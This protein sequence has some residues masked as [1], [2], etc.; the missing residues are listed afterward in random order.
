M[1][2]LDEPLRRRLYDYVCEQAAPVSRE[3]AS[4]AADIVRT[5]AAYH[6]DKLAQ[7][8]LLSIH[9]QHPGGPSPGPGRPAKLYRRSEREFSVSVPPRDYELLANLLVQSVRRD[10]TGTVRNAMGEAAEQ[11]GRDAAVTARSTQSANEDPTTIL[12]HALRSRGYQP[13]VGANCEIELRNCPFHRIAQAHQDIVCGL[14]LRLIQGLVEES[15]GN[16]SQTTLAPLPGR[17][18]VVIHAG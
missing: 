11:A 6:L 15:G 1:S 17:C 8:G 13:S 3:Q 4:A 2:S 7:A 14:N 9:Y 5:L 16:R 10:P 18:C 12:T